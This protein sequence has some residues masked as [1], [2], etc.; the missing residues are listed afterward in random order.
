MRLAIIDATAGA[1]DDPDGVVGGRYITPIANH[2]LISHVA[3]DLARCGVERAIVVA[4]HAMRR[5]LGRILGGGESSGLEV[6]YV[7]ASETQAQL[8]VLVETAR[9]LDTEPVLLHP[10]DCLFGPQLDA[11]G[12][13]FRT[14]G[15]DCVLPEQMSVASLRSRVHR[16]VVEAPVALGPGTRGVL[17]ALQ[18]PQRAGDDLIASLLTSDCRLAV[19]AASEP[20]C[21]SAST[22]GLLAGNRIVLDR[23]EPDEVAEEFHSRNELSGRISIH[24]SA[25]LSECVIAGPVVIGERAVLEGSFVGPYTSIG[26]GAILRGAEIDNSIVLADAEIHHP[27]ARLESCIIGERARVTRS[28]TLPR[29]IHLRLGPDAQVELS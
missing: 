13:R 21:Y 15:V 5:D 17:T 26:A 1:G 10:G 14:G 22:E 27:G 25:Y 11:M 28:F 24:P 20:W 12:K 6:S 19:C 8:S 2:P 18:Q 23:L 4:P 29:G 16:R 3:A 7:D 9:A